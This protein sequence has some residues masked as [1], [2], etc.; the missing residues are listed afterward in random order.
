MWI[1]ETLELEMDDVEKMIYSLKRANKSWKTP[2]DSLFDHMNVIQ[3]DK[4][5]RCASKK[6]KCYNDCVDLSYIR[7]QIVHKFGTT[8]NESYR[9]HTNKGYTII[10]RD[11]KQKSVVL[12]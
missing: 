4:T 2:L 6:I 10:G 12:V 3:E 9:T 1:D 7:M 5:R 11:F 8:K